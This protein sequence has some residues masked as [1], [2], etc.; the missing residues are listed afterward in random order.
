M[1]VR[2]GDEPFPAKMTIAF[3]DEEGRPSYTARFR[4]W[5]TALPEGDATF[6]VVLPEDAQQVEVAPVV[7]P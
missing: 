2:Q 6:E 3:V 4:R 1:W 5:S 7:R